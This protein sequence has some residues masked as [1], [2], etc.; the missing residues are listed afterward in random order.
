MKS[1]PWTS[2]ADGLDDDGF[3][4]YDRASTAEDLQEIYAKFFSSGVYAEPGDSFSAVAGSGM[5][6]SVKP[7]GCVINGTFGMELEERPLVIQAADPSN[8]RKDTVVLRWNKNVEARSIDLYVLRG[9]PA[10]DPQRPA[11]TRNAS[12]YELGIADVLV[13]A[14]ASSVQQ[15]YIA[16]TRADGSRCG[17]VAPLME[18]DASD[19]YKQLQDQ[20][21][22]N[23]EVIQAA[24]DDAL[25]NVVYPVGSVYMSF[26][27]TSPASL[28]GGTW[29]QLKGV[30][31]RFGE[32]T[33]K[34]GSDSK[35]IDFDHT[36]AVRYQF[37][38]GT[39]FNNMAGV[40]YTTGSDAVPLSVIAAHGSAWDD[41]GLGMP[42]IGVKKV[43]AEKTI[44]TVPAYQSLY[45]W[46]RTA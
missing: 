25:W 33:S 27:P 21:D 23:I 42:S 30:F 37:D 1:F 31:P 26:N 35:T 4:K 36:H 46:R 13:P 15:Q 34:G 18:F 22:R 3:P 32:N 12:V 11:L 43:L 9:T 5:G 16:D 20:V 17:Y 6:V 41:T 24:V 2:T 38:I 28:F 39:H 45:A 7:G 8:P 29:E 19:L 10:A 44:D 14:G 40:K